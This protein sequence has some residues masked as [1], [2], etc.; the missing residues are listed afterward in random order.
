MG[1]LTMADNNAALTSGVRMTDRQFCADKLLL[2]REMLEAAGEYL[3]QARAT[4]EKR[5]SDDEDRTM[6]RVAYD[7]VLDLRDLVRVIDKRVNDV[8]GH[9]R[10]R[11]GGTPSGASRKSKAARTGS[12]PR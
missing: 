12:S 10:V 2:V 5:E 6:L 9:L 4:C 3:K 11:L 1:T 7:Q 8:E